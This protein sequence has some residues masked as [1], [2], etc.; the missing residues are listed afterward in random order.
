MNEMVE[1]C[2]EL[3]QTYKGA[4]DQLNRTARNKFLDYMGQK[5]TAEEFDLP[6]EQWLEEDDSE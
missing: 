6:I 4:V 2:K 5:N 1:E 3:K